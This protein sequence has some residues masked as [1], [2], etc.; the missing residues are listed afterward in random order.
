ME[1][2]KDFLTYLKKKDEKF[3]KLKSFCSWIP[4]LFLSTFFIMIV[5]KLISMT[6]ELDPTI[7]FIGIGI[8]MF[9]LTLSI[10]LKLIFDYLLDIKIIRNKLYS[11][12]EFDERYFN[13]Y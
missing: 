11:I 5:I 12:K 9:T 7:L 13:N 2:P 1:Q 8:L 3:F 4:I 6:L 10:A